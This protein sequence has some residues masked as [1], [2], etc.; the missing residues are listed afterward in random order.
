MNGEGLRGVMETVG[1]V[2]LTCVLAGLV[3]LVEHWF[4]WRLLLRGRDLPVVVRYVL[5]VAGFLAPL[6]LLVGGAFGDFSMRGG[7]L[8][9]VMWCVAGSAGVAVG[10]AYGV[11]WVLETAARVREGEEL[12]RWQERDG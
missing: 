3:E 4:P 12:A 2:V 11:D 1:Q 9:V 10:A 7:M 6:S 8:V 5:G